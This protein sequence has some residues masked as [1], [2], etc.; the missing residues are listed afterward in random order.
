VDQQLLTQAIQAFGLPALVVTLFTSY[1]Y[2]IIFVSLL[3]GGGIIL[4][5]AFYLAVLGVFTWWH[6]IGIMVLATLFADSF[7]YLVGRGAVPAFM[8]SRFNRAKYLKKV[9]NST[10]GRELILLFYSKFVYGTRIAVQVLC[11]ARRVNFAAYLFVNTATVILLG[12]LYYGTVK[13]A[14]AGIETLGELRYTFVKV[15]VLTFVVL[16]ALHFFLYRLLRGKVLGR[17]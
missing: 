10:K 4:F 6:I 13:F 5:P 8:S 15:L 9:T 17:R 7:W 12:L 3:V 1:P 2:P 14:A 16:G 11:G